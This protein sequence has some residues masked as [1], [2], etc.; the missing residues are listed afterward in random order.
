MTYIEFLDNTASE[1]ICASLVNVPSKVI[2]IGDKEKQLDAHAKRYREMFLSRGH[3][4]EFI[5]RSITRSKMQ[6]IIDELTKIVMTYDNC[7]IDLTGGDELYLTAIGIVCERFR[8]KNIQMH[9][10]NIRNNK[11]ADCDC[12]GVTIMETEQ[13][14]LSVEENI[15]VFGGDVVY[16][17]VKENGT[18]RWDENAEFIGDVEKMWRICR[19]DPK[20]WNQ[21][22]ANLDAAYACRGNGNTLTISATINEIRNHIVRKNERFTDVDPEFYK[23]LCRIGVLTSFSCTNK[24]LAVTFKNEQIKRCLLTAGL[25]LELKVYLTAK[26]AKDKD[27]AF[28][29]NDVKNGVYIDWDG[30][31]HSDSGTCDTH[32][33][34]DVMMMHG[35]VPVF[36]SC[37]NGYVETDELYKL[38]SVAARFGG[39][40]AKRV[41]VATELDMRSDHN[42][43]LRQR[44]DDMNIS[45]IGNV[46][47]MTDDELEAELIKLWNASVKRI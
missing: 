10:Y 29:Y 13:P 4:V 16:S 17:D 19:I 24:E 30:D 14:R 18:Y 46:G 43:A 11:I 37:K 20:M 7:V 28:V 44:A 35:I 3:D 23:K 36:V 9:R 27:G 47:D 22:T 12:D 45:V 15:R 33:E 2:L 26:F 8:D 6:T 34:I 21:Q 25:V 41:L 5:C 31:I 42:R 40:Y 38:S 1:N 32:N 39:Q